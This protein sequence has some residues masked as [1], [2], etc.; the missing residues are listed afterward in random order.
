MVF[1]RLPLFSLRRAPLFSLF[2]KVQYT[3]MTVEGTDA[4]AIAMAQLK[5]DSD[6]RP[7][8]ASGPTSLAKNAAK[9]E[10][11]KAAKLAQL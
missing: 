3:K 7:A 8:S 4:A 5:M 6:S 2:T 9:N 1:S 10:A 11:K